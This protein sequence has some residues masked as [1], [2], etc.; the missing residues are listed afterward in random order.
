MNNQ[1]TSFIT[2]EWLW[3][4][5]LNNLSAI[6]ISLPVAALW[7][8]MMCPCWDKYYYMEQ[9]TW[10][11]CIGLYPY[12]RQNC[13][14]SYL[15]WIKW[16]LEIHSDHYSNNGW[17]PMNLNES[18]C[19]LA[20]L[21]WVKCCVLGRS[22]TAAVWLNMTKYSSFDNTIIFHVKLALTFSEILLQ[23]H[24]EL[25]VSKMCSKP[26]NFYIT[27]LYNFPK[28]RLRLT[29]IMNLKR[30]QHK[31][32]VPVCPLVQCTELQCGKNQYSIYM[33]LQI[34]KELAISKETC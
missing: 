16:K 6:T 14:D 29:S 5:L 22:D 11:K 24:L 13:Y 3:Y 4:S 33:L 27:S 31:A 28:N 2:E 12:Y 17:C 23:S 30:E 20:M 15:L 8:G 10:L 7:I 19:F 21:L 1:A 25:G 32:W 18:V 34:P 26:P 9:E